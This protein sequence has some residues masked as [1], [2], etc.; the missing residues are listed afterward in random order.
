MP[1]CRSSGAREIWM[2]EYYKRPAPLALK[3]DNADSSDLLF[4]H[5]SIIYFPITL[6]S[7]NTHYA[8]CKHLLSQ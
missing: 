1:I 5:S 8:L 6:M 3:P 7:A 4:A 2:I